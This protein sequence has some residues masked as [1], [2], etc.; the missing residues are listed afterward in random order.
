[1]TQSSLFILSITDGRYEPKSERT[2]PHLDRGHS[3]LPPP[4]FIQLIQAEA[5]VLHCTSNGASWSLNRD[6]EGFYR[7]CSIEELC[8]PRLDGLG[9]LGLKEP[10][11]SS[12]RPRCL[13]NCELFTCGGRQHRLVALISQLHHLN[14]YQHRLTQTND[15]I[16]ALEVGTKATSGSISQM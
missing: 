14:P 10:S 1:M 7:L 13:R 11:A 8:W 12:L 5:P 15:I 4:W 6:C 2:E 9:T 16:G 3:G